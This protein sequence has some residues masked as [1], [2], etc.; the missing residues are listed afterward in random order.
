MNARPSKERRRVLT[1]AAGG[2]LALAALATLSGAA[3]GQTAAFPARGLRIV[4]FGTGGGPIDTLAR[5]YRDRLVARWGQPITVEPRPGAS[6]I[7]AADHVARSAPDGLTVLFTMP[8]TH[9]NNHILMK[10]P[11]DPVRD[12]TPLSLLATGGPMLV[13][14]ADA[15]Y[16]NV[17]EFVAFA[18]RKGRLTYGTWG[19]G[20]AAHLFGALLERQSGAELVHVPYKA[21]ANVHAD[22]FGEQLDFAWAN[23]ATARAHVQSGRLKVLAI[24]GTGRVSVMPEVA[25][26]GE[27]GFAGFDI[28][29]WI[30]VY[31][32]A[33]IPTEAA[34]AWVAAL[35]ETTAL[36]EVR[37]R[38]I[39][40]GFEPLG[41]TPAR[42]AERYAADYPRVA[43]LIKVAGV[44]ADS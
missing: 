44:T 14:R 34:E 1:A 8:L 35:R 21:E 38:L 3:R 16:A 10:L 9:I 33:R 31:A 12:F 18:R 41:S 42:F 25:T 6:G 20:S 19:K 39:A 4:P 24:A 2:S 22:L 7:L 27:Q 26:F 13:A 23:P 28:D 36:P 30:G 37:A 15:P 5:V 43:E 32:P 17:R 11:Y 29:S 40:Y